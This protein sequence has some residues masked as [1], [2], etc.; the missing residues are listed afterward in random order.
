LQIA[1]RKWQ[2][3]GGTGDSKTKNNH[4]NTK[5]RRYEKRGAYIEKQALFRAF[6]VGFFVFQ[7]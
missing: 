6:V 1:D 7:L 4:E 3:A 5:R 2:V